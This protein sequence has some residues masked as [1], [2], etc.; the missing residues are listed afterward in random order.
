MNVTLCQARV[1]ELKILRKVSSHSILLLCSVPS[2]EKL[3]FRTFSVS[4]YIFI[5]QYLGEVWWNDV[6]CAAGRRR[7]TIGQDLGWPRVP[8]TPL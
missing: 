1:T 4:M 7:L 3:R 8:P 2:P 5:K 6:D